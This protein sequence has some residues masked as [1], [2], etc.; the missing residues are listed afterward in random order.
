MASIVKCPFCGQKFDREKVPC[1]TIGA[2]RYAH[3]ECAKNAEKN[4]TQEEK[5]KEALEKYIMKLLNESYINAR[6]RKQ[7]NQ[8]REEYNYTYSG[9]LKALIY[10]FE[11][12]KNSIEKAN[13]GIG[14]VPYIYKD[15]YN[16]YYAIWEAQ[17]KNEAK[18]I[19]Q[20]KVNS[21][22]WEITIPTPKRNIKKRN[23]FSFLDE[24]NEDGK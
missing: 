13:G 6:V 9:M 7:I 4:K 21:D 12:K 5:D 2:R 23:L 14:I 24:E 10:F 3:V 16:Y 22:T 1:V 19:A 15:A 20:P 18:L 17:Q 8:Y 11:V